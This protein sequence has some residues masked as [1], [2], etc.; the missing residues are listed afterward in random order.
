MQRQLLLNAHY[1]FRSAHAAKTNSIAPGVPSKVTPRSTTATPSSKKWAAAPKPT[2][3][4]PLT[5]TRCAMA[6][7]RTNAASSGATSSGT[8]SIATWSMPRGRLARAVRIPSRRLCW[9]AGQGLMDVRL[10]RCWE[11]FVRLNVWLQGRTMTAVGVSRRLVWWDGMVHVCS[12]RHRSQK[13]NQNSKSQPEF[14]FTCWL[15]R[16]YSIWRVFSV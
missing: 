6:T 7:R 5:R 2:R 10:G 16:T 15:S 9:G 1:H 14:G 8:P 13:S 11:G 12:R 4:S 3:A